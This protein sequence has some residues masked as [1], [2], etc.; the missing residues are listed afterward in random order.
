MIEVFEVKVDRNNPLAVASVSEWARRNNL[1]DGHSIYNTRFKA[2]YRI[3]RRELKK[4]AS[5][6]YV[7]NVQ[8]GIHYVGKMMYSAKKQAKFCES[9]LIQLDTK[10]VLKEHTKAFELDVKM[11]KGRLETIRRITKED[12]H[13]TEFEP[14]FNEVGYGLDYNEIDYHDIPQMAADW[15]EKHRGEVEEHMK[16]IQPELDRYEAFKKR[17]VEQYKAEKEAEKKAKK[18][19]REYENEIIRNRKKNRA[20]YKKLE[21]SFERYYE[22]RA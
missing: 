9:I 12:I 7:L 6:L 14:F 4:Q 8:A 5:F 17:K 3:L 10:E 2:E 1:P 15:N 18:E 11:I 13:L 16:R 21:R 20:E 22:G 19:Q